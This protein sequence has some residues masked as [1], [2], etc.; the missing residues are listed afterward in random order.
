M[1]KFPTIKFFGASIV[2][3]GRTALTAGILALSL[4]GCTWLKSLGKSDNV[5]PPTELTEFTPTLHVDRL[6]SEGSGGGSGKSGARVQPAVVDGHVYVA[7]VD[8]TISALDAAS[9]NKLWSKHVGTRSGFLFWKRTDNTARWSGGP[10]VQGDLVVVGG[11]DGQ[12]EAFAATDGSERWT[13]DVS[14][15]V[16]AP[17]AIADGIVVVRTNDGRLHGLDGNDG[18]SRWVFDQSVPVLSLRGN[19]APVI[20]NGTVYTGFD[21]GKV[22]ALKLADGSQVWTQTISVGEGRTEVDRLADVDGSIVLDNGE[23]F[24][25]GY[26]G[27]VAAMSAENGR[28][29]W[30]RDLSSY[31]G[32]AANS[33]TV[34]VVASDGNVW[35]F[36]RSSGANL[37]KQDKLQFRWLSPPAIVGNTAVVGDLDGYVHWMS[38]DDGKLV[39]RERLGKKPIESAPVVVDN[40]AY[41]MDVKGNLTAY[42]VAP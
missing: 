41:I 8:G 26:R 6:W 27:Q 40:T 18:S 7:G 24:A 22:I 2:V 30:Q 4:G 32:V 20:A 16:I 25:A 13:V 21:N 42:R 31:A 37:W 28:Q 35:A 23:L 17:P 19:S 33:T 36:D 38:L 1:L 15:E 34:V 11:L 29:S 39:A 3:L 12:V 14:S 9:G 10:S 5:E